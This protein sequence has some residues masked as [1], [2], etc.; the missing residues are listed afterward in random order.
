MQSMTSYG[1]SIMENSQEST[2]D[3]HENCPNIPNRYFWSPQKLNHIFNSSNMK[4][5]FT[6]SFFA[7][8]L[9]FAAL[10]QAQNSTGRYEVRLVH[11]AYNCAKDSVV[12]CVEIRATSPD[13]AFVMGNANF[14]LIYQNNQL[15]TPVIRSRG[16]FSGGSYATMTITRTDGDPTS[17]L[18]I[19]VVN[20]DVGGAGTTVDTN[21]KNIGCI[22]FST[23][24]NTSKCYNLTLSASNPATI[25][26]RAYENP[27]DPEGVSLT[28]EVT[29]GTLTSI[30]NQCP[31][32]P[33]VALS[34]GG[35]INP[36]ENAT[37]TVTSQNSVLP[38]QVTL[39]GNIQ[40]TLTAQ[41]PTKNVLVSPNTNTTYEIVSVTGDCGAGTGQ[42]TA[43][44][45]VTIPQN[46]PPAKCIPIVTRI[47]K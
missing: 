29:Q 18:S 46:C 42:G 9:F 7:V 1:V 45:S 41:E 24:G 28:Q 16:A 22:A 27:S 3:W 19:N 34:G 11:G 21:W 25:V 13:S 47:V 44:V 10:L 5:F 15:G 33:T 35:T 20:T 2:F 12:V 23:A 31:A 17:A 4:K 26:T 40:V 43:T 39:S 37:L 6:F 8:S 14:L 32:N 38:A 30:T 36:G